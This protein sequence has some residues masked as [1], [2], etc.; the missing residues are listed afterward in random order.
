MRADSTYSR[1]YRI[2]HWAI[3]LCM[4]FLLLTI[5]L[6]MGW[7]NKQHMA[8]IIKEYLSSE[9]QVQLDDDQL[10]TLAKKIRKP[11]WV[12]HTYAGYVLVGLY[13]IRLLL[14]FFGEM[15]F[16]NPMDKTI[17]TKENFQ[18]WTYIVF[19][20]CVVLSLITGLLIVW[21]SDAVHETAEE[22]HV[23]SIYYLLTFIFLHFGSIL[24]EE[25]KGNGIVS[26]IIGG[27]KS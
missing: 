11:M 3:A 7:M 8:D 15:K 1:V 26:K 27:N 10:I 5:F 25:I 4:L 24:F 16:R 14:P 6:R 23:L 2:M 17:S 19:H 9:S 12:W 18:F 13:S 20:I 21:G 22:I